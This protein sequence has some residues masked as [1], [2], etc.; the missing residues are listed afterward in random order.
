MLAVT[1]VGIL[2]ARQLA[3][4]QLAGVQLANITGRVQMAV[5]PLD[6]GVRSEEPRHDLIYR[7]F[8]RAQYV[9]RYA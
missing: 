2:A 1:G 3:G 4:V 6:A 8:G 7:R 5:G 9:R